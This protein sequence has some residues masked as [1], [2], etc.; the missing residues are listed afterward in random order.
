[1]TIIMNSRKDLFNKLNHDQLN[2]QCGLLLIDIDDFQ[3]L[4]SYFG[5]A[6]GDSILEQVYQRLLSRAHSDQ[7]V[8]RVGDDEFVLLVEKL[9]IPSLITITAAQIAEQLRQDYEWNGTLIKSSVHIGVSLMAISNNPEALLLDAE[10]AARKAKVLQQPFYLYEVS[11]NTIDSKAIALLKDV[12]EALEENSFELYYQPKIPLNGL[13]GCYSE[14]LIRWFHPEFGPIG[15]DQFLPLCSQLGLNLQLSKWV[16]NT[17]LRQ[18]SQWPNKEQQH[19]AI[20]LF[21]DLVD[22]PDL[23][24][25][26]K[27]ALNIWGA[28]PDQLTIEITESAII[29]DKASGFNN[30]SELQAMGV[31]I[32]IDDFGTGYSSLEYFKQIPANELKIDRSFIQNLTTDSSDQ[33]IVKLIINLAHAFDLPVVAEGIEE[34]STLE[35]LRSKNCDF[36][37]GYYFSKP[38]SHSDYIDWL[39]QKRYQ[40]W[41]I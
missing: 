1:M 30:L 39:E 7:H 11:Q 31:K 21:A 5:F 28:R 12:R 2:Q 40:Q 37:Q 16:I 13:P 20:N 4:N 8:F 6:C 35:Q 32:S 15:P 17:A 38:L 14:A 33:K 29:E 3:K 22:S 26:V 9:N 41:S 18:L 36:A 24:H 19:V 34:A 10:Q 27:S 25:I 23:V